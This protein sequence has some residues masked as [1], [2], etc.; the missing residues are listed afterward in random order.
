[1]DVSYVN[2]IEVKCETTLAFEAPGISDVRRIEFYCN[3]GDCGAERWCVTAVK[4]EGVKALVVEISN[5]KLKRHRIHRPL[6]PS[7]FQI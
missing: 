4:F 6:K 7:H 5:T 1:L 2:L 3:S